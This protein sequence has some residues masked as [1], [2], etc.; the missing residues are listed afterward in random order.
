MV[1]KCAIYNELFDHS[2]VYRNVQLSELCL[3]ANSSDR[4]VTGFGITGTPILL[5]CVA[6]EHNV[7]EISVQSELDYKWMKRRTQ[8][9][10]YK[11]FKI[12]TV[13]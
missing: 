12:T 10:S 8:Q 7:I 1:T 13:G 2:K 9:L 3:A 5:V 4:I 11:T 6:L